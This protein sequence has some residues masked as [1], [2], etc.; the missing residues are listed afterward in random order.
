MLRSFSALCGWLSLIFILGCGARSVQPWISSLESNR[1]S[2]EAL[3][4][5]PSGAETPHVSYLGTLETTSA[6]E[7]PMVFWKRFWSILSGSDETRGFVRPAGLC[8]SGSMLVVA[9]PGASLLHL[10][11]LET[12]RWRIVGDTLSGRLVS[13]VDVAC[14]PDGRIL[15]SD[16]SQGVVFVY[17]SAGTP[18]GQFGFSELLRPTGLTFDSVLER[19]WL[20]ETVAH[21]V[22]AFDLEGD[23][24][25]RLGVRGIEY[26]EFNYPTRISPDGRGGVWLTD[27]LNFRLQ[28]VTSE[29]EVDRT[30]GFAGDRAGT[31]A[32]PRG[33]LVDGA[34]RVLVVD[35]L[36]DV[37][38]IFDVEGRLLLA[39]GGRG[40]SPGQ[41]WLPS[42]IAL[43]GGGHLFVSDSYNSR[44]QVF[45][46]EP[47]VDN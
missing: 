40:R 46:Y 1:V 30:L 26:G 28:H 39:F 43:D 3:P 14:L 15:T 42:G 5:W 4:S 31:L 6:F 44:V 7:G 41:F 10:I 18:L 8:L 37:V 13:P 25:L 19:V 9:D 33:L 20:T 21:R 2:A 16:S 22:L 34:G 32:R 45:S 24:I 36:L 38:Q 29:G 35:A 27:S 12:R 47:P 17:D 11:D 23:E